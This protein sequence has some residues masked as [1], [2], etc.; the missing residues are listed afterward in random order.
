MWLNKLVALRGHG[1]NYS[2]AILRIA[3]E[4]AHA[5]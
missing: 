2:D 4:G 1:E 3:M 5:R